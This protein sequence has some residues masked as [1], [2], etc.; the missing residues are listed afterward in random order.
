MRQRLLYTKILNLRLTLLTSAIFII[1]SSFANNLQIS[2]PSV[3]GNQISFSISWENSWRITAPPANWDAV[4]IFIKYQDCNDPIK[5]WQHLDLSTVSADHTATGGILG[6]DAVADGKGVFV[7]RDTVGNGDIPLAT[8]TLTMSITDV[9]FNYRIFGIE[10]VNIPEGDFYIGDGVL[11]SFEDSTGNPVKITDS[12]E[13]FNG[14]LEVEYVP[15]GVRC[16]D[17]PPS[18]PFGW[19][20]FYSM[21][22]EIS[23]EQY[24]EF[25]NSLTYD[26][27]VAV[28]AVNPNSPTGADALAG[29]TINRNGIKINTSGI[30][31]SIPAVYMCDLNNNNIPNESDDGQNIALNWIKWDDL[32]AY[33]D[34]AA[35]RPMTE[36]EFE[37]ICR[38]TGFPIPHEYPWGIPST[39]ACSIT[40]ASEDSLLNGTQQTPSEKTINKGNGL[41][42]YNESNINLGPLRCGFAA[43]SSTVR[44]QAGATFYGVMDM[45]GNVVE[46]TVKLSNNTTN[47]RFYTNQ[48]GDG[49]ISSTGF[50]NEP[51]WVGVYPLMRGGHWKSNYTYIKISARTNAY[52]FT[53]R[54]RDPILGGRGVRSY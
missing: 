15:G 12:I 54:S 34:W 21:K 26:Q 1:Y 4:W 29:A 39:S 5:R 23:Q 10:M 18:F 53:Y 49:E 42:A 16:L 43:D 22:Y 37:K 47:S 44:I 35:L 2:T 45:G 32:L 11:Y 31:N 38:G 27:Q 50:A 25:L 7:Y 20:R 13:N 46:L 3:T 14:L 17:L 51:Q 6:V 33:L 48:S 40:M 30:I 19:N 52:D 28:T 24:V 8:I 41:C 9:G 36:F